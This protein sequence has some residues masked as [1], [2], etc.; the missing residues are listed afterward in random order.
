MRLVLQNIIN[1]NNPYYKD[2]LEL[3][4]RSKNLYNATLYEIRQHY[5][6]SNKY[7]SYPSID[8][9]FK[10]TNNPDYR[11]LP[12]QAAQQ[13]MRAVDS[14]FKSF[15]RLASKKK[16]KTYDKK[17]SLPKYLDKDGF[18]MII[19][20][21]QT[22]SHKE[23]R[24]GTIHI[25]KTDIRLKT[26]VTDIKQVRFIPKG[27]YVL[28]EIVYEKKEDDLRFD[29]GRYASID[30]GINNLATVTSNVSRSYIVNGKPVKSINQYYNKKRAEYQS[31]L[32]NRKSSNRIQ[33]LT[34]KR[35]N[36]IK[37]YFHKASAY[38]TN[39]LVSDS[40]NTLI[41]GKND[42]WKQDV[43][44]GTRNNQSFTSI[45]HSTF[46]NMIS[47][48]CRMKGINVIMIDEAYTSKSSFLDLD[49]IPDL[50][51]KNI[52]SFSGK[53]IKRGIY[54]SG[55]GRII[56]A[57]VNGSY[58]I[59]RKEVGDASM[60]TDRGFVFNPVRLDF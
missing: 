31:K 16:S 27:G 28:M 35:N 57:D 38:I 33:R 2:I 14:S 23:L 36:K 3:C 4:H 45:P 9:K 18:Y 43:N 51:D 11:S 56:N 39:Q 52:P 5:F 17:I 25:P 54:V 6:E 42:G 50:K 30:L 59:M 22:L 12:A 19:F 53:R 55:S 48:K 7:L 21:G 15:F 26:I 10:D 1:K 34:L 8:K 29:N 47:Y 46:I 44:M 37:D 20:P 40:I 13:T 24:N 41:I 32:K 58:N 60:P 49:P